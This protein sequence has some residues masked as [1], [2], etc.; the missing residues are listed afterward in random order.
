M[1]Y[2]LYVNYLHRAI[3][4]K[5]KCLKGETFL[6]IEGIRIFFKY[7]HLHIVSLLTSRILDNLW[8]YLT[9]VALPK[10]GQTD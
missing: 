8:G 1:I 10:K 4:G 2:I 5:K 9:G 7:A 3:S 6:I